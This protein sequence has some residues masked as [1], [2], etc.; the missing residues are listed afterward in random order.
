MTNECHSD[1]YPLWVASVTINQA[2]IA[3][4]ST[5]TIAIFSQQKLN[6]NIF[7]FFKFNLL[8]NSLFP[9]VLISQLDLAGLVHEI[10]D[11]HLAPWTSLLRK[12]N[13]DNTPLT[14]YIVAEMLNLKPVHLDGS[15]LRD[16]GFQLQVPTL[17]RD[18]LEEVIF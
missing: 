13:I 12:H 8:I 9:F 3:A 11:K 16:T 5:T 7:L 14:P 17:R 15:K 4:L 18:K 2:A 6:K 1:L 10:N